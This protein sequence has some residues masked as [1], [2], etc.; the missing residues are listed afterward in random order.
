MLCPRCGEVLDRA[1]EGVSTCL[2]CEGLWIAP[3]T[4]DAAFGNPCWP[5]GNVMWWRNSIECPE[6]AL[7]GKAT[8]MSAR[9]S[10]DV[11]VDQCAEHGVWLDRGELG[12]LM[13]VAGDE[14]GALRS[15]VQAMAPDLDQL[16]ARRQKWR[17]DLESRRRATLE[18]RQRLEEEHR[19]RVAITERERQRRADAQRGRAP[20]AP[21][22]PSPARPAPRGEPRP[23]QDRDEAAR[24]AAEREQLAGTRR[25][26]AAAEVARL[27]DRLGVL[28]DHVRRLE[29]EIAETRQRA[30]G[31]DQE[32]DAALA[33]LRG[34]D[35]ELE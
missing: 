33:K 2:R 6:C 5:S 28:H 8:V 21:A 35:A 9:M 24:R 10:S 11:I 19:Q 18:Y 12:R 30:A 17:A 14:L 3:A 16:V 34:L 15:R 7:E 1:F 31:I 27:Q 29:V 25:A 4:L 32:L 13:G 22:E 26:Q 20:A 23:A